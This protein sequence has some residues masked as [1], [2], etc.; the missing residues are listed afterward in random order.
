MEEFIDKLAGPEL[1]DVCCVVHGFGECDCST[2]GKELI[3]IP[4]DFV[5]E[6]DLK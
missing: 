2:R 1:I 5:L 4:S 3:D 6:E